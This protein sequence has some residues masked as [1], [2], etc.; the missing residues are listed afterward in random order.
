MN[1]ALIYEKFISRG[2]LENYL[3]S[4]AGELVAQ[5]VKL[6]I[7]TGET[8][9]VTAQLEN[10]HFHRIPRKSLKQF[11]AGAESELA[12]LS[13]DAS[14][15]FG[16]TVSHDLHRAGGG[17]H[18]YYSDHILHP[19]KRISSKNRSELALERELY[20]SGKTRHF[21]VNSEMVSE[22]LQEA[23]DL[24]ADQI[25]VI[26]TAVDSEK[27]RPAP[28]EEARQKTRGSLS[29]KEVV[30]L[31][32]S[33]NHRRKG[34]DALLEAWPQTGPEANLWIVGPELAARHQ[35]AIQKSGIANRVCHFLQPEDLVSLYQAADFFIHPTLYDACAN[36][37]LQSMACGLPGLISTRDGAR[38]F[39]DEGETG[40]L[41]P[42]PTDIDEIAGKVM[43][44]S[45]LPGENRA[46][47]ARN[48]RERMLPLTWQHHVE[49]WMKQLP[50]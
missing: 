37:V 44:L 2:G 23:Y 35:R 18:R 43:E 25:S 42:Y 34:L 27:F 14:I 12:K 31:F 22:Q 36:T 6:D 38:Q 41:L 20:I 48:C 19:L 11:A 39:V 40:F 1:I 17:C 16:R 29:T 9:S 4:L 3:Y 47:M 7:I 8:D 33:M 45:G 13:V 5:G 28:S 21:I 10:C 32:V 46:K 15:G 49:Q 26:H 30:F 24:R 50:D